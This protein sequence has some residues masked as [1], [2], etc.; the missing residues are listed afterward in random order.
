MY[1]KLWKEAFNVA[2]KLDSLITVEVD[3]KV[4]TRYEHFG[5]PIPK[6]AKMLRTWG[7]AV[8]VMTGKGEKNWRSRMHLYIVGY[9]DNHDADCYRMYNPETNQVLEIKDVTWLMRMYYTITGADSNYVEP[10]VV[11]GL[12]SSDKNENVN[13]NVT[14][15]DD[16]ESSMQKPRISRGK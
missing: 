1:Y 5:K 12:E 10:G 16:D 11:L 6:Y 15:N 8:V 14:D 7:E 9:V 2:T 13:E 4:Q 3:G